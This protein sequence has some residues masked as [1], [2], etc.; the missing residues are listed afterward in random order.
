MSLTGVV[1]LDVPVSCSEILNG[2]VRLAMVRSLA[3]NAVASSYKAAYALAVG[4]SKY[5]VNMQTVSA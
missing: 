1:A 2:V 4:A 5:A 3:E